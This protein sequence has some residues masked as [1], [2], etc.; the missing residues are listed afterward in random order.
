MS[1][2]HDDRSVCDKPASPSSQVLV[3]R[4][5]KS[6]GAWARSPR[7]AA[8]ETLV[9]GAGSGILEGREGRR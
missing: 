8:T 1:F 2:I 4:V 9:G 3:L 6:R 7:S 5:G